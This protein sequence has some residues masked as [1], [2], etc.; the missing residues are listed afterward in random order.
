MRSAARKLPIGMLVAALAVLMGAASLLAWRGFQC[1]SGSGLR[2]VRWR[3]M[4]SSI[5]HNS[6]RHV[7]SRLF[8]ATIAHAC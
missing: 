2:F 8:P 7:I 4:V 1:S 6:R 3:G 5:G